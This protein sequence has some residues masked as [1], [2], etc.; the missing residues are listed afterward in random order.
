[1]GAQHRPAV[2]EAIRKCLDFGLPGQFANRHVPGAQQQAGSEFEVT[3]ADTWRRGDEQ[4]QILAR[5]QTLIKMVSR[6]YMSASQS[7]HTILAR[8]A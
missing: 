6:R 4:G 1:M 3:T 8:K 5:R 7:F 2:Q